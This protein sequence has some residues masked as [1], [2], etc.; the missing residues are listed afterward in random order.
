MQTQDKSSLPT[1]PKYG[2][3]DEPPSPFA[4]TLARAGT[5]RTSASTMPE[6]E[7]FDDSSIGTLTTPPRNIFD[8]REYSLMFF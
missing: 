7:P 5:D 3:A 4:A 1:S 8:E 6:L 2:S